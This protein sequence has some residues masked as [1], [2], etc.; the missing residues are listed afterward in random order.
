MLDAMIEKA[1]ATATHPTKAYQTASSQNSTNNGLRRLFVDIAAF[2]WSQV[3]LAT[4][5]ADKYWNVFFLDLALRLHGLK[6]EDR[7]GIPPFFVS[8]CE[9]HEHLAAKTPCYRSLFPWRYPETS[10]E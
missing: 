4:A 2:K 7:K 3:S 6:E 9:Y 1:R 10:N 5:K 8:T